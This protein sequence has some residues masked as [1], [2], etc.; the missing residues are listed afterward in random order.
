LKGLIVTA[1]DFGQA[2]EVNEAV[3]R[4]HRDGILS[5]ASLMVAARAAPDA[6]ARAKAMTSL[7]V[8]LHLVLV[9]G[10][11]ILPASAV[12]DLVDS[13]GAF[14]RDMVLAAARMFFLAPVRDQLAHEI[15]EDRE[16]LLSLMDA[17]G[18]RVDRLKVLFGWGAEKVGRLK[19]NGQLLGYS[20]LSRLEELEALQMGV[21][22]KLGLWRC[23]QDLELPRLH[24]SRVALPDLVVRAERQLE[25]LDRNRRRA[26]AAALR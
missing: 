26:A 22:A 15:A 5:A 8:G 6:V 11:P 14:R 16:A 18:V 21:Y 24:D 25:E 23:L 20:P 12:P 2:I 4:A 9:D 3:E 19:F 10:R 7:R 17:L 13:D 1:D